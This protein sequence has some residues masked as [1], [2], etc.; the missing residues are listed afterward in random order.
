M[1]LIKSV[2]TEISSDTLNQLEHLKRAVKQ[3]NEDYMKKKALLEVYEPQLEALREE[4]KKEGIDKL[5]DM[6]TILANLLDELDT[7]IQ[8]KNDELTKLNVILNG[9]SGS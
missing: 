9:K 7:L 3:Y 5:K 8:Q 6:P 4:A 2:S 1:T